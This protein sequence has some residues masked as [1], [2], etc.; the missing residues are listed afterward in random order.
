MTVTAQF[1]KD[2]R[3]W[4]SATGFGDSKAFRNANK[5]RAI[6]F[7]LIARPAVSEMVSTSS[8]VMG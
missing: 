1:G 2:V 8:H 4:L 3:T 6:L 5:C 7:D